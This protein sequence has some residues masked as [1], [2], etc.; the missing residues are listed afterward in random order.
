MTEF[1]VGSPSY[2]VLFDSL[3]PVFQTCGK[4]IFQILFSS[5]SYTINVFALSTL[6]LCLCSLGAPGTGPVHQQ[7]S[8]QARKLSRM[9]VQLPLSLKQFFPDSTGSAQYQVCSVCC[10]FSLR[11]P[12]SLH[13]V[14]RPRTQGERPRQR[15]S[16]CQ[17][18]T[19]T[20]QI[21]EI[22]LLVGMGVPTCSN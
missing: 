14:H 1:Q 5:T 20:R 17:N 2:R 7:D 10:V 22:R 13:V 12:G 19:G 18:D 15:Q 9:L 4:S 8:S 11:N 16:E 6:R 3:L 21:L